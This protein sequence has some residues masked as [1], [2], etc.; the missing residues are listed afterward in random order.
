MFYS[1]FGMLALVLNVIINFEVLVNRGDP[2]RA[3]IR[4][5]YRRFILAS[6]L[7][8][9]SDI[10]WGILYD[11]R[12]GIFAYADTVLYFASMVLTVLMW[13][14]YIVMF[15]GKN[16]E[17][18]AFLTLSG[19]IIFG[20]EFIVLIV[21][22]FNPIVFEFTKEG[23]YIPLHARYVTLFLQILLQLQLELLQ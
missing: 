6:L 1:S 20:F 19:W 7:Y 9:C 12:T 14:R 16:N 23:E 3:K 2:E 4:R 5:V 22:F 13:T 15:L 10:C 21:N 8:F 17:L 18:E 11:A